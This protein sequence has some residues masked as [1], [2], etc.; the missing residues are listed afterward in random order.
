MSNAMLLSGMGS[1]FLNDNIPV[2][3]A[4]S[5]LAVSLAAT[6]FLP[7]GGR[8]VAGFNSPNVALWSYS[9][10]KSYGGDE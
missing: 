9:L 7:Y 5:A 1:N 3:A 8:L 6:S 10:S 4:N 2:S